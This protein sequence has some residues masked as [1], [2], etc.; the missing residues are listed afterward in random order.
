MKAQETLDRI[1]E[2]TFLAKRVNRH[3]DPINHFRLKT[4][5]KNPSWSKLG[6]W[7][8]GKNSYDQARLVMNSWIY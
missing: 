8:Q 4:H 6:G 3:T 1:K 2:L 5:S 7:N